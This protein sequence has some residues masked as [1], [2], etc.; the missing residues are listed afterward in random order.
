MGQTKQPWYSQILPDIEGAPKAAWNFLEGGAQNVAQDIGTGLGLSGQTGQNLNDAE[1]NSTQAALQASSKAAQTNDPAEKA[2][3]YKVAGQAFQQNSQNASNIAKSFSPDVKQNPLLRAGGAA[4]QIAGGASLGDAAVNGVGD[5]LTN[6]IGTVGNVIKA[7]FKALAGAGGAIKALGSMSQEDLV[8]LLKNA[9]ENAADFIKNDYQNSFKLPSSTPPVVPP[10]SGMPAGNTTTSELPNATQVGN[11]F[12]R[13]QYNMTGASDRAFT[14]DHLNQ[15][16]GYGITTP[17]Q[18]VNAAGQFSD[19]ETGIAPKI[20]RNIIGKANPVSTGEI[21]GIDGASGTPGLKQVGQ[22]IVDT[23]TGMRPNDEAKFL[24]NTVQAITDT[25]GAT[26]PDGTISPI[27]KDPLEFY[28]RMKG[29]QKLAAINSTSRSPEDQALGKAYYQFFN[30]LEDRLYTNSGANNIM[31]NTT[32]SPADTQALNKIS[33][34][35]AQDTQDVLANGTVGDLRHTMQPFVTG[36]NAAQQTLESG[37]KAPINLKKVLEFY[38]GLHNPAAFGFMAADTGMGQNFLGKALRAVGGQGGNAAG[39]LPDLPSGIPTA[40]QRVAGAAASLLPSIAS[41]PAGGNNNGTQNEAGYKPDN[42]THITPISYMYPDVKTDGTGHYQLS[43][44][45]TPSTTFMTEQQREQAETGLVPGEPA[46]TKVEQKFAADQKMAAAQYAPQVA[47]FMQRAPAVQQAANAL[48]D[49]V[50]NLPMGIINNYDSFD[51][52]RKYIDP[53]YQTQITQI[54]ALNTGFK[55]LFQAVTGE[56]PTSD[57]LV[58]SKDSTS[59]VQAKI[60]FI[61]NYF[62]GTWNQYKGAYAA[63]TSPSGTLNT[64]GQAQGINTPMPS[65]VAQNNAGMQRAPIQQ[66]IINTQD[67]LHNISMPNLP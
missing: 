48:Y 59:A 66:N 1:A 37:K 6:P 49:Q 51:A 45:D 29:I 20:I 43:A 27:N 38:I 65:P 47:T 53:K 24:R 42:N 21:P 11:R 64:Q 15:L 39:V 23:T 13:Q 33:P 12:L 67:T 55:Q 19:G 16:A 8:N 40:T 36:S 18:V 32:L 44:Q 5:L 63:A 25:P 56:A 31:N 22:N 58:S 34:K 30:D 2:R 61:T 7:P 60:A 4:A 46:Y 17:S 9:P 41:M 54:D 35:L 26:L 3:L 57:M 50:P 14:Q 10:T 62:A 28:D 52:A